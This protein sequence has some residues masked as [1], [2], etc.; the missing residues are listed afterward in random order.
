MVSTPFIF[1]ILLGAVAA[2]PYA[3]VCRRS[4]KPERLFAVGFWRK[5]RL[6]STAD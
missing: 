2:V 4:A 6:R 5:P 1:S 3:A